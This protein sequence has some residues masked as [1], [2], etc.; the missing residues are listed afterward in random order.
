MNSNIAQQFKASGVAQVIVILRSAG[1]GV[2]P[3][4]KAVLRHFRQSE[5]SQTVMLA[6]ASPAAAPPPA[7]QFY[8]H[9]GICLGTVDADGLSKLRQLKEAATVVG[10]PPLSII[11]P[12]RVAAARLTQAK[13]WGIDRLN[14]P[15][16]W[17]KG[18]DG[19]GVRV[20]HL[21]TGADGRHPALRSA[22]A[23]F[24]EFDQFGREIQPAPSPYDTGDHGTHT[25][26]TIAGRPV[27]GRYI[28]VA[29]KAELCSAIV[30]EGGDVVARVLGGMNWAVG[31]G[32]K[33]LS[34][35]L[36]FRGWWEDFVPVT[37]ILR[38][39]GVLPV[40]AVGNEGPGTS[41]SP[42]NYSE[43]L[44]V[45][46]I[47]QDDKV[48]GFSS[49]DR[50]LREQDPLVPDLVAPG[51]D[52]ISAK[53]QGGYQSMDGTSMATPH[54]AGLA[55]LLW[56]SKPEASVSEV[57]NALLSSCALPQGIQTDRAGRGRPDAVKALQ[58][59]V[60]A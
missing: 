5:Y 30:I 4:P 3:D 10:A 28:G 49:S 41:R 56:Q 29:P 27:R 42:G 19:A 24:A 1:A 15:E 9:L 12:D 14:I 26:G 7:G 48:A 50:F 2:A 8:A 16:L 57:E 38:A 40:F 23:A 58:T 18:L 11:R 37:R 46:A 31:L 44:S 34:M 53:P 20:A 13:T 52:V 43:A 35:S 39:R 17:S 47:G 51:V 59:L 6:A 22:L 55:A 45:G 21:D 54:V 33:V 60:G 25:A 32:A 36:G